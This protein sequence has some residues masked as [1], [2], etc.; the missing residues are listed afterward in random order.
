[1]A[2]VHA[3]PQGSPQGNPYFQ[4][5]YQAWQAMRGAPVAQQALPMGLDPQ[6]VTPMQGAA[7]AAALGYGGRPNLASPVYGGAA[8]GVTPKALPLQPVAQPL[9]EQQI[10]P[11]RVP[12]GV[13]A[14]R[15]MF[16][17]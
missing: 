12:T 4:Q 8:T 15:A 3:Q 10:Q 1:M 11:A 6:A 2:R 7:Q 17:R 16:S 5:A 14:S 13:S 9:L